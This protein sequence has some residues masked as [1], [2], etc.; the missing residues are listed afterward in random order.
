MAKKTSGDF[1]SQLT[2]FGKKTIR[3]YYEHGNRKLKPYYEKIDKQTNSP[4]NL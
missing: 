1:S 2:T 4:T 3:Y